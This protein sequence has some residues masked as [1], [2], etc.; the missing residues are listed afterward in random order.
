MAGPDRR[1]I[2]ILVVHQGFTIA[3]ALASLL[4]PI[5]LG[6]IMPTW[7]LRL[8]VVVAVV[9]SVI[10]W[11]LFQNMD[12]LL[13]GEQPIRTQARSL[14]CSRWRTGPVL[15]EPASGA[16]CRSYD[17]W[18]PPGGAK[19]RWRRGC[20]ERGLRDARNVLAFGCPGRRHVGHGRLRGNKADPVPQLAPTS[21]PRC[22]GHPRP[23][24]CRHGRHARSDVHVR[25]QCY[26]MGRGAALV[27]LRRGAAGLGRLRARRCT[28]TGD[29]SPCAPR[30]RRNFHDSVPPATPPCA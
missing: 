22:G 18:P 20:F 16:R 3:L 21:S 10:S 5:A 23:H 19:R 6:A 17:A 15:A 14:C 25:Q 30:R 4:A 12:G 9:L 13:A 7:W 2:A 28:S 29:R 26:E 11:V 24:G 1:H 8:S 27:G